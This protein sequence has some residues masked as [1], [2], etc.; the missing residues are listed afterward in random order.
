[1]L[2]AC[3]PSDADIEQAISQTQTA[4]F[5]SSSDKGDN[6]IIQTEKT[7]S[8]SFNE[9]DSN[10]EGGFDIRLLG[11][12]EYS[13]NS[14]GYDAF[15]Y[16]IEFLNDGTFLI[17][18]TPFLTTKSFNFTT[19]ES[20]RLKLSAGSFIEIINYELNKNELRLFFN[21]GYNAYQKEGTKPEITEIF[22][23]E[24]IYKY[25]NFSGSDAVS[26]FPIDEEDFLFTSSKD[27]YR[28]YSQS[29][30][31]VPLLKFDFSSWDNASLSPDRTK[32]IAGQHNIVM[33]DI[34]EK[35]QVYSVEGCSK[36][37]EFSPDG[38]TFVSTDYDDKSIIIRDVSSG[39]V[40][41]TLNAAVEYAITYDPIAYSPDGKYL[42]EVAEA[43]SVYIWDINE[44]KIIYFFQSSKE[45][46]VYYSAYGY[47]N[48]YMK[49]ADFS[50]DGKL[51]AVSSENGK[52]Y[53]LDIERKMLLKTLEGEGSIEFSPN[54]KFLAVRC[55]DTFVCFY[56]IN[57]GE[58]IQR[59]TTDK[60]YHVINIAF[61]NN[62][63][64]LLASGYTTYI[65]P[66]VK[67]TDLI[68]IWKI[69]PEHAS[70]IVPQITPISSNVFDNELIDNN[71][72]TPTVRSQCPGA[73]EQRLK[74]GNKGMV[75]TKSDSL[76]FRA[77][78]GLDETVISSIKTG[79]TFEVIS[80][81]DC[82]GNDWSWWQV[83]LNNGQIGWLAEGGD[84][85][86]PYFLCPID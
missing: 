18:E 16:D 31:I 8:I 72:V 14:D 73:P 15:F 13:F 53:V 47:Q 70:G 44:G 38:T 52:V 63:Q 49:S 50:P 29:T 35:K 76:R 86:D 79:T 39:Y 55:S 6:N 1:M 64:I 33:Y 42:A 9:P 30:S 65:G 28:F 71:F 78:P 17:P 84:D 57:S 32:I 69:S 54:G 20:G 34:E 10:S 7:N 11:K 74:V 24:P 48:Y 43:N 59:L 61:S 81:P 2:T 82:A 56:D 36:N 62:G 19:P 40:I 60:I 51:L 37:L 4:E 45:D 80:G 46:R 58:L 5:I 27:I 77:K 83:R 67:S 26:L 3:R 21:D 23:G 66:S 12:W 75:C 68:T 22:I 25:I 41:K 85:T